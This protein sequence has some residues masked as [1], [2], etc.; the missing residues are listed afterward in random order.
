MTDVQTLVDSHTRAELDQ[1]ASEAGVENPESL[2]S[3]TAVAEAI[4]EADAAAPA[5]PE[6]EAAPAGDLPE[7][8]AIV[9]DGPDYFTAER[10]VE[11]LGLQKVSEGAETLDDLVAKCEAYDAAQ[12][13]LHP[14]WPN[15]AVVVT[16][17]GSENP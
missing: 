1:I 15:K 11:S 17:V 10:Y 9:Q 2:D 12:D 4:V 13:A 16:G 14:A 8:W 3:K 7:G 6:A 5:E